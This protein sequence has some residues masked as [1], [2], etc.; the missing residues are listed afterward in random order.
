MQF[1]VITVCKDDLAGLMRTHASLP[2]ATDDASVEWLVQD[3]GSRDGT[4]TWLR[5]LA[6]PRLRWESA[7]DRGIFDAMNRAT[8]RASGC[9]LLYLNAGDELSSPDV[10][11]RLA[12]LATTSVDLM[13]GDAMEVGPDGTRR[14]RPAREPSWIA[15]GMFTHHQ[16][17][18]FRRSRL[19]AAPY[20]P[21]FRLSGDYALT[22]RLIARGAKATYVGFPIADFHLGGASHRGRRAALDEDLRVRRDILGVS[23]PRRT[24]LYVAHAIHHGLKLVVPSATRRL[25]SRVTTHR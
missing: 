5:G 24:R 22:A 11:R 6:D 12:E 18:L 1:S 25:R 14:L 4:S 15:R 20:D 10:L 2:R 9:W 16:S 7:R 17:M 21:T 3:G 19:P 8:R 13:Y 23:G